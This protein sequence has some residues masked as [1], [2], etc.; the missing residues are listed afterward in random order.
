MENV[1]L[2]MATQML[3]CEFLTSGSSCD[4]A[5]VPA[6]IESLQQV[7]ADRVRHLLNDDLH[8]LMSSLYQIDVAEEQ[9]EAAFQLNSRDETA[10]Y[11]AGLI[12]EREMRK[13]RSR[14]DQRFSHVW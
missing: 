4:E 1:D 7:V 11:I 8:K 6:S 13:A 3:R 10:W 5:S 14:A 9:V 12:I 2:G